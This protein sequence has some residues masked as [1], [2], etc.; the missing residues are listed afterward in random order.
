MAVRKVTSENGVTL[1]QRH[2]YMF[3]SEVQNDRDI[4]NTRE[5][6]TTVTKV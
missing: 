6:A 1:G 2:R 5:A 4:A 3:S